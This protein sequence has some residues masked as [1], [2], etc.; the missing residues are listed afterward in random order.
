[1]PLIKNLLNLPTL[2]AYILKNYLNCLC[3]AVKIVWLFFKTLQK[4]SASKYEVDSPYCHFSQF[5][6]TG[7]YFLQQNRFFKYNG[8]GFSGFII[9]IIAKI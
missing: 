5:F 3:K 6:S 2:I 8:S 7:K 1:M 9:S 4:I